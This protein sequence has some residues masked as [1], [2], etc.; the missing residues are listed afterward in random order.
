MATSYDV[1]NIAPAVFYEPGEPSGPGYA[2][3]FVTKPHGV[4][5]SATIPVTAFSADEVDRVVSAAAGAL[6]A[7][8]VL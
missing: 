3:S 8:M 6:E 7:A 2:V 1:T 5:G 4:R